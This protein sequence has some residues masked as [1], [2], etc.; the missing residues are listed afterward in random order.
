VLTCDMGGTSFD[1]AVISGGHPSR[2]TRGELMG[3]WTAL[4][5]VDVES[6]SAGGGSIGWVDSRGM[7]RVGPLSAGAVPGPACY[8]KGGTEPTVTDALVVLGYIDPTRFLGGG[9]ALDVDAAHRACAQI[10]APIGLDVHETAWG[11][12]EIAL[13][14]MVKAVRSLVN[15]RGL[16][17]RSHTLISF[18][19]CG[20]LF[21]PDIA[22]TIRASTVLVPEVASVLS[23]FG[24]A[25]ADIRRERVHSL[26]IGLPTDPGPLQ[27][28]AEKL[29]VEVL[30]DLAADG[31]AEPDRSVRFE[32][33]LRFK[34]QAWELTVPLRAGA[35]TADALDTLVAD[36][37]AEYARRYGEGS[38][39]LAVGVELVTLRATGI[40][41]T[42]RASAEALR[43]P[44]VAS[45]TTAPAAGSR[46][47]QLRRGA[48]GRVDVTTH[49]GPDLRPG[50]VVS[51][52]ALVD[53]LD[54]TIWIPPDATAQLDERSTLVV[55][56][57]R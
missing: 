12:R 8:G 5:H 33:D 49:F 32:A 39:T 6:I 48:D 9:M 11:I 53:G 31:V 7:L 41:R 37:R 36:F 46:R 54:T 29:A 1:V 13:E 10:G 17:A 14:G 4:P 43:R 24:A 21:T 28:L 40:G 35:I 18:G 55:E 47:V 34:R 50:H 57:S 44:P 52:P 26:G 25:T 45:G 22:R 42:V 30:D 56:V 15:E 3:I 51:G 23:A 2:R 16:D 19:G 20:S 38:M 27:V